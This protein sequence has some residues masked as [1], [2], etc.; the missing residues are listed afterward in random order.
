[1]VEG[2]VLVMML[3]AIIGFFLPMIIAI[4]RRHH[5]VIAIV[6]LNLLLGWTILGW[7]GALVWSLT[8]IREPD[9][10]PRRLRRRAAPARD[11]RSNLD[12]RRSSLQF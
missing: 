7:V 2:T 11:L 3:L 5:N 1:M 4:S 6:F 10:K 8:A 12:A 9:T